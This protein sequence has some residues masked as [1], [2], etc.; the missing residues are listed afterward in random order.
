MDVTDRKILLGYKTDHSLINIEFNFSMFTRGKSF[1]KFNISLLKD[2]IFV[3]EIK[4]TI[5]DNKKRYAV[6]KY[7]I[8]I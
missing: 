6:K 7:I 5:E 3:E 4:R 1:R 2:Q 8:T